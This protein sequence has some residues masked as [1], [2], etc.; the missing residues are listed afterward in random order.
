M[1]KDCEK[2][3][4]Q[5]VQG[6]SE[7]KEAFTAI[8]DETRQL[9]LM[10]L[11]ESDLSG[12]RVGEIARKTHLTRPSVSH[13]LKILKEADIVAM[14]KEGTKNYYY[15]SLDETRWKTIAGLINLIYESIECSSHNIAGERQEKIL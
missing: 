9:I 14:R 10:V 2:R 8:G 3:L 1:D 11:L 5:I 6:F 7:C 13:H 12:I 15:I 4:S